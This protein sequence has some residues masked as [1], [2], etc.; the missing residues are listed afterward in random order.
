MILIVDFGSQTAHLI[1]RR[2]RELGVTV[3]IVTPSKALSTI[4]KINPVGIILSGGPDSVFEKGAPTIDPKIFTLGIPLLG[5]CY[6]MQLIAHLNGGKVIT[7]KKE[8]GPALLRLNNAGLKA[9]I[10]NY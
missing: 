4:E 1:G 10:T 6:G 5:I 8:Y 3:T 7:N 2:L 9:Q